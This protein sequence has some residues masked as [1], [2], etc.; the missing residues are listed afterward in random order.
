MSTDESL[1][2]EVVQVI[3]A[4]P[5]PAVALSTVRPG[6]GICSPGR[7]PSPWAPFMASGGQVPGRGWPFS[8][9]LQS[10]GVW[11]HRPPALPLWTT[12]GIVLLLLLLLLLTAPAG[13]RAW[14]RSWRWLRWWRRRRRVVRVS[15]D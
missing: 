15:P 8:F 7:V 12:I 14:L 11:V 10:T 1:A 4:C 9:P 13:R 2:T 5:T 3:V 6:A